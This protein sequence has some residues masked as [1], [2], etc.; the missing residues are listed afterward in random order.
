MPADNPYLRETYG[1]RAHI[2]EEQDTMKDLPDIQ[3]NTSLGVPFQKNRQHLSRSIGPSS[4]AGMSLNSDGAQ[5]IDDF[6]SNNDSLHKTNSMNSSLNNR[7]IKKAIRID[8]QSSQT[9]INKLK[10]NEPSS[11]DSENEYI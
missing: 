7:L 1:S 9:S 8:E 5:V 2:E 10:L 4:A 6:T 11:S 3:L